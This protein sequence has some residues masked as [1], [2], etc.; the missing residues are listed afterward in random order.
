MKT[1]FKNFIKINFTQSNCGLFKKEPKT[2]GIVN[3]NNNN[4]K[5]RL[6]PLDCSI[7]NTD[8]NNNG[9]DLLSLNS[10]KLNGIDYS[11]YLNQHHSISPM[12][13]TPNRQ[14]LTFFKEEEK[15]KNK[16][17]NEIK[18]KNSL[19]I[20]RRSIKNR[21]QNRKSFFFKNKIFNCF[22]SK[23]NKNDTITVTDDSKQVNNHQN[24]N[25][26][27]NKKTK[28]Q[29]VIDNFYA[30]D[31]VDADAD[32]DGDESYSPIDSSSSGEVSPSTPT[33]QLDFNVKSSQLLKKNCT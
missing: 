23:S 10:Y 2:N 11:N 3:N 21:N 20:I 1:T 29:I 13:S 28:I 18:R 22:S 31:D 6:I 17:G 15:E 32:G 8:A 25:N 19:V 7:S 12:N 5:R 4:K 14:D 24:N 9:Q 30:D 16:D 26:N 33:S 27:N